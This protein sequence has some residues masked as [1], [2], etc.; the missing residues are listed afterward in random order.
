MLVP[1]YGR[2]AQWYSKKIAAKNFHSFTE[3]FPSLVAAIPSSTTLPLD[4]V[5]FSA[6]KTMVEQIYSILSFY[7]NIGK[8]SLW[9][10]YSDKS[11]S[12][13]EIQLLSQIP[14]VRVLPWDAHLKNNYAKLM[15]F[16][17]INIWGNRLHAYLNHNI[18]STTIFTDSDI[19]F[20]KP[21]TRFLNM[22]R[23][24]N[25][26]IPDGH[27]HF[28]KYYFQKFGQ[29]DPPY[30]N[31]GFMILNNVPDWERAIDYIFNRP[32]AA[33]W[34]HF[35]EQA[36]IHYMLQPGKFSKPLDTGYFI[37]S[38]SD[39]FKIGNDYNPSKIALR[40]FVSPVRHKMW[41]KHWEKVLTIKA[42]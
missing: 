6:S 33:S 16:G 11:H 39:S 3:N 29:P 14:N 18:K 19:L 28:D 38:L 17:K 42:Q 32:D 36:S 22:I 27:P 7:Y 31:A 13:E 24:D 15:E 25:W 40:H 37:L 10:I 20:Y 34:E 23:L 21:F 41:Q 35:T 1:G 5:S 4:M 26:F 30:V 9:T 12:R 2:L 8:P